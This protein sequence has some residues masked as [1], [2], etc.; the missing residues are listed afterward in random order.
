M[1]M[2]VNKCHSIAITSCPSVAYCSHPE[3]TTFD[4]QRATRLETFEFLG[5]DVPE[6][7]CPRENVAL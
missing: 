2:E 6:L 4:L 1:Q 5:C 7:E 3:R